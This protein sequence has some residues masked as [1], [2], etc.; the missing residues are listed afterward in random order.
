MRVTWNEGS[1]GWVVDDSIEQPNELGL[2]WDLILI[3][4]KPQTQSKEVTLKL[5]NKTRKL[6]LP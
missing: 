5:L 1:D 3:F 4:A 2:N 6:K